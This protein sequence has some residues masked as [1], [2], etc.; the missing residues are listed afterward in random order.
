MSLNRII[1]LHNRVSAFKNDI[2]IIIQNIVYEN[3]AYIVD[4]NTEDQL[5]QRGVNALG[6]DISDY[7]PYSHI[8]IEIKRL[9]NQPTNRV[10]L[11]DTGDFHSSFYIFAGTEQFEINAKDTKTK[12][13]IAK[14]GRQ[15]LGL[16]NENIS[17]LIW[18]YI[19]PDL[20]D[21]LDKYL[22]K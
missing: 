19:F 3:E 15:I 21:Q 6:V 12:D 17:S 10:T 4:M 16:T 5:Y 14:Y 8:T 1:D 22:L 11:R 13:L 20:R 7:K 2:G 18:D 9:K